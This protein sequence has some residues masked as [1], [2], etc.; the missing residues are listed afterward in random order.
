MFQPCQ[1][2]T[3]LLFLPCGRK[4]WLGEEWI[5]DERRNMKMKQRLRMSSQSVT[6][7]THTNSNAI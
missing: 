4:T 7:Y 2:D 6:F 1:D 3:L 5:K